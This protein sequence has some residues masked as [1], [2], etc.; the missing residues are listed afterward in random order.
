[1]ASAMFRCKFT[2]GVEKCYLSFPKDA[3]LGN[4][5]YGLK[6]AGDQKCQPP[7]QLEYPVSISVTPYMNNKPSVNTE[8]IQSWLILHSNFA[9]CIY[10]Q[11]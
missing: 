8:F 10:D 11:C 7:M 1:M 9:V 2:P 6:T 4:T 5:V 3:I